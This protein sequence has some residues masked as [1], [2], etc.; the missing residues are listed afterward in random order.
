V[1]EATCIAHINSSTLQSYRVST[2]ILSTLNSFLASANVMVSDN[3]TSLPFRLISNVPG[4]YLQEWQKT[5]VLKDMPG[6]AM[7]E[8]QYGIVG[9]LY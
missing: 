9:M 7:F 1:R 8:L 6:Q 3:Q 2:T 4:Q 5:L